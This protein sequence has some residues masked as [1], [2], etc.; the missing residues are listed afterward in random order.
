MALIQKYQ[1]IE[2]GELQ[3][4]EK[5]EVSEGYNPSHIGDFVGTLATFDTAEKEWGFAEPL[6]DSDKS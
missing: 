5:Y 1:R 3:R 6:L 4:L 2:C